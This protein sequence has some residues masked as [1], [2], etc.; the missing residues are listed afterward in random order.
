MPT[1]TEVEDLIT[2]E[3]QA[4]VSTEEA[5]PIVKEAVE[6]MLQADFLPTHVSHAEVMTTG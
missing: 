1:K 3:D 4:K 2:A 6:A 5:M